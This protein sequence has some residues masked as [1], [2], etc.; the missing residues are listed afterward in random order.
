MWHY[1]LSRICR[2]LHRDIEIDRN[3]RFEEIKGRPEKVYFQGVEW[4]FW[5]FPMRGRSENF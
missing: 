4:G 5:A 2:N 3:Q 1:V